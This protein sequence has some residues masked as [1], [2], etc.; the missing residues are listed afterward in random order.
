MRMRMRMRAISRFQNLPKTEESTSS[1]QNKLEITKRGESSNLPKSKHRKIRSED[2]QQTNRSSNY[3]NNIAKSTQSR[4]ISSPVSNYLRLS[5]SI[6][7][8]AWIAD[9]EPE[10]SK[11]GRD[12]RI[13]L[14]RFSSSEAWLM[15]HNLKNWQHGPI[16]SYL[17]EYRCAAR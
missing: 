9:S 4:E 17:Y 7:S 16:L 15:R 5:N 11:S 8:K 10:K 3:K 13:S 14:Q 2:T 12:L 1:C 6:C